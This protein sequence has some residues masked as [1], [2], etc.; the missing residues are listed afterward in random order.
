MIICSSQS[1]LEV[2]RKW[3]DDYLAAISRENLTACGIAIDEYVP[4]ISFQLTSLLGEF[5]PDWLPTYN[6]SHGKIDQDH[7]LVVEEHCCRSKV[8]A[9]RQC[10]CTVATI[11]TEPAGME[12]KLEERFAE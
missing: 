12:T 8:G 6:F 4:S 5:N 2:S 3:R 11:E 7:V 9:K 10:T 1:E